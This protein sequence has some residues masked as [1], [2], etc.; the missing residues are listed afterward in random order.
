MAG[1]G[2]TWKGLCSMHGLRIPMNAR[3]WERSA[4]RSL[5]KWL[6]RWFLGQPAGVAQEAGCSLGRG[7]ALMLVSWWRVLVRRDG[8]RAS[9]VS[10]GFEGTAKARHW[11]QL[12]WLPVAD[13]KCG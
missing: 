5:K 7:G 11:L 2:S 4:W 10:V 1:S 12:L 8:R 3:S 13:V 6:T 9:G